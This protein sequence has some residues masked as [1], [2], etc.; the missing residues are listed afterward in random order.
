MVMG[1]LNDL[2]SPTGSSPHA[3]H[4]TADL[5]VCWD[6]V[7]VAVV[8]PVYAGAMYDVLATSEG[9]NRGGVHPLIN[10]AG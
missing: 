6:M 8:S 10:L 9:R 5:F 7:T 1:P 4:C 2:S 3:S